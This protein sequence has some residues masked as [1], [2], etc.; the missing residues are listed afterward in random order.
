MSRH[1][2]GQVHKERRDRQRSARPVEVVQLGNPNLERAFLDMVAFPD[3]A[4]VAIRRVDS[5]N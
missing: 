2:L 4:E 3:M 5:P 1:L